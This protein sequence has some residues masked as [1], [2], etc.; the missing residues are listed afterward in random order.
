MVCEYRID[1][2]RGGEGRRNERV[3]GEM[4]QCEFVTDCKVRMQM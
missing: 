4:V 3:T 1:L 2:E